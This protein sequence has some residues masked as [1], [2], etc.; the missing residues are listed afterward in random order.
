MILERGVFLDLA[1]IHNGDLRLEALDRTMESFQFFYRTT[2]AQLPERLAEAELVIT[3]KVPLDRAAISAAPHLKLIVVCA[4]GVDMVDL[5]AAQEAG[6]TVC[7]IRDYCSAS[8]AQHVLT[9]MLNLVTRQPDYSRRAR[10]GEWQAAGV[11]SLHDQPIR[12]LHALTLG[13]IGYGTLGKAVAELARAVG[14]NVVVGERRG[15]PT[16]AERLSFRQ[17][18]EGVDV[19]SLH[20]PLTET[21]RHMIDREVC[22]AMKSTALLINTARGGL[23]RE[24]DLADALRAGDIAGAGIDVF[25][26]E[27]PPSSHPLLAED[28]PNLLITPHNAWGSVSARQEAIDQVTAVIRS[29][30]RGVPLNRVQRG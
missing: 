16:R 28:I 17:L 8:V 20:C 29:F 1:T 10:N 5:R 26:E 27:P 6:V 9:L 23:V 3:N 12:E 30:E 24:Q 11:F 19:L 7:N 14:M 15:H 13:I 18:V 4:T 2:A 22:R 21:T 25:S